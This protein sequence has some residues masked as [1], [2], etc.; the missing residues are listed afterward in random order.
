[1][2]FI[3]PKEFVDALR[4][5]GNSTILDMSILLGDRYKNQPSDHCFEKEIP[6]LKGLSDVLE[7]AIND[8]NKVPSKYFLS[9]LKNTVDESIHRIEDRLKNEQAK[10]EETP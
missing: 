7:K 6:F 2:Q 5:S 3:P 1:M 8:R 10:I 9:R 4:L